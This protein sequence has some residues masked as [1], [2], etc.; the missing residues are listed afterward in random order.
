MVYHQKPLITRN[1]LISNALKHAFPLNRKGKINISLHLEKNYINLIV[2]DNGIS[3]SPE[4][5]V[6]KTTSLSLKLIKTLT[7]QL[8]GNLTLKRD[9][10]TEFIII[11]EHK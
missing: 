5:D 8:Q 7:R 11:F 3:I 6:Y 9:A 2:K 1:E 4:L 10:G